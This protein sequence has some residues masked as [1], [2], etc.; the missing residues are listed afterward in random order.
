MS[1]TN[2]KRSLTGITPSGEPHIG[3]YLG[4]IKP[5]LEKQDDY[6]CLY[7]L[8][9]LHATISLKDPKLLSQYSYD[10]AATWL[11]LGLDAETHIF[12]RQSDVPCVTEYAWLLSCFTG[13]GLLSKSHAYK[14]ALANNRDSNH[15]LFAYPVLMAA[16]IVMYDV[17]IVPVGKDQKQ[18]VEMARDIAGSVNSTLCSEVVKV[19]EVVIKEEVMTIPGLDGRK[20]SKSYGNTI[21][22][23]STEKV[24]RKRIMSLQTDSSG[25]EEPKK[26]E[27]SL[28][29][30]LYT[31]FSTP[32]EYSD[33]EKKLAAG[34]FG[35]GH[36]KEELFIAINSQLK[37]PREIYGELRANEAG[38]DSI[39]KKG[40]EKAQDIATPILDRLRKSLGFK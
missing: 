31:F 17:D 34:G 33:L 18:H 37:E 22:L 14:D 35:W 15:G 11:A 39:L 4:M 40:A 23:F 5:A 28:L 21:P 24:L 20:M 8:S 32:S 29:G 12:Y 25:L 6:L 10:L 26:L 3:N 19:P 7:F 27:G 30:S 38:L 9:D 16:D 2:K 36:A 1:K 13:M